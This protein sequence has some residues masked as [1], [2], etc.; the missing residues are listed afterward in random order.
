MGSKDELFRLGHPGRAPAP[1][2][3]AGQ[4]PRGGLQGRAS[5]LA[6]ICSFRSP[7]LGQSSLG[8]DTLLNPFCPG[9][10]PRGRP[11]NCHRWLLPGSL[12]GC[13]QR[14][15]PCQPSSNRHSLRKARQG[16]EINLGEQ[17]PRLVRHSKRNTCTGKSRKDRQSSSF[18]PFSSQELPWIYSTCLEMGG[19]LMGAGKSLLSLGSLPL[20]LFYALGA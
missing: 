10:S 17:P 7:R 13:R 20:P 5:V 8:L 18:S 3:W 9:C 15:S 16:R 11:S 14:G 4:E 6:G 1:S 2:C 19:S 12:S